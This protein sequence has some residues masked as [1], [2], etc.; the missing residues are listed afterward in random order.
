MKETSAVKWKIRLCVAQ[1]LLKKVKKT[2]MVIDPSGDS[3]I[4]HLWKTFK[5]F[6]SN[7]A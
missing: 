7:I 1:K 6:K 2:R 4:K 5:K 3:S